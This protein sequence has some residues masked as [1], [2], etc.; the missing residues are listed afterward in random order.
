MSIQTTFHIHVYRV[1]LFG[2]SIPIKSGL[3]HHDPCSLDVPDP[4]LHEWIQ[5]Y[6]GD[7]DS[8]R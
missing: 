2:D 6:F 8:I 4:L 5:L 1:F 3:N 7:I